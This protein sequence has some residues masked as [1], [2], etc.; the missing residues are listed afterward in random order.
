MRKE[1]VLYNMLNICFTCNDYLIEFD[2]SVF[3][4]EYFI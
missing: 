2:Q 1:S 3:Y 4:L